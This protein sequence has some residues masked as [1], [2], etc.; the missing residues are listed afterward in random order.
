VWG[1]SLVS[2]LLDGEE[3]NNLTSHVEKTR[4]LDKENV[5]GNEEHARRSWT[6]VSFLCLLNLVKNKYWEC[7]RKSFNESNWKAFI[8][9]MNVSFPNDVQQDWN[10]VRDK[11][12]KMTKNLQNKQRRR[13][14]K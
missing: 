13:K 5:I 11:W 9:V 7:N 4:T 14:L 10:K 1:I 6:N 3:Q 2:Y 8:D 12:N